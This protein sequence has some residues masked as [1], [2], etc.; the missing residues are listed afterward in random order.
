[1]KLLTQQLKTSLPALY[2]CEHERDPSLTLSTGCCFSFSIVRSSRVRSLLSGSAFTA[3]ARDCN[4]PSTLIFRTRKF[5]G[6]G[7][8]QHRFSARLCRRGP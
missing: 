2:I 6:A 4:R 5:I 1:M 7:Q 3:V 8:G